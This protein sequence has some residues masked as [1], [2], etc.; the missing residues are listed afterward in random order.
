M[1]VR[2]CSISFTLLFAAGALCQDAAKLRTLVYHA[3]S[4]C[5]LRPRYSLR[6]GCSEQHQKK[7]A[8]RHHA[9]KGNAP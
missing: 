7:A 6:P 3:R 5:R 2:S 9:I 1:I 8:W 4:T